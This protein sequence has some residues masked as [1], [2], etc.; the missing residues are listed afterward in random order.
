MPTNSPSTRS[1]TFIIAYP[2]DEGFLRNPLVQLAQRDAKFRQLHDVLA[3]VF[4]DPQI[5]L[6]M[7]HDL[8]KADSQAAVEWSPGLAVGGDGL[9]GGRAAVD[10]LELSGAG[11]TSQCQ[12]RVALGVSGVRSSPCRTF[13]R[14]AIAKPC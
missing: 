5:Q 2:V 6:A 1:S 4:D 10:E 11:R 14:S 13:G 8:L 7:R 9:L 3:A 12:R